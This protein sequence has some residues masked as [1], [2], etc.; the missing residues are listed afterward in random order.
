MGGSIKYWVSEYLL[1]VLCILQQY[2]N[3]SNLQKGHIC[4]TSVEYGPISRAPV[5]LRVL[6]IR[7]PVTNLPEIATGNF[8]LW[9]NCGWLREYLSDLY[10]YIDYRSAVVECKQSRRWGRTS[11]NVPCKR[12]ETKFTEVQR[13]TWCTK[14]HFCWTFRV[15][16][17]W[18]FLN[19]HLVPVET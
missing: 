18:L 9:E 3:C 14:T 16:F 17:Q 4:S 19:S 12:P 7:L 2:N 13:G 6:A 5:R 1:L 15:Y 10:S 11:L 8:S